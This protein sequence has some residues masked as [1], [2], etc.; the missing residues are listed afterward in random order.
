[1][2]IAG[3]LFALVPF[4]GLMIAFGIDYVV[5]TFDDHDRWWVPYLDLWV[6]KAFVPLGI[7]LLLLS[8]L[9]VLA[10]NTI[11]LVT[12]EGRPAPR[13]PDVGHSAGEA[14]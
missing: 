8:G 7:G 3:I 4:C 1:M 12:G 13:W 11:F 9:I 2:E 5:T 10:R 6:K 14:P